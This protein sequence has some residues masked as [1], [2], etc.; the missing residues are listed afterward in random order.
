M[1]H[2]VLLRVK[3]DKPKFRQQIT[4]IS[5]RHVLIWFLLA[6]FARAN[7][8][9][10]VG[11]G[12]QLFF[13]PKI[14]PNRSLRR[15]ICSSDSVDFRLQL[16]YRK[17]AF[18]RNHSNSSSSS[19]SLSSS[20]SAIKQNNQRFLSCLIVFVRDFPRH[21][22]PVELTAIS[23][24]TAA[25]ALHSSLPH[26]ISKLAPK[27]VALICFVVASLWFNFIGCAFVFC[28]L[29]RPFRN[30]VC[31]F[32]YVCLHSGLFGCRCHQF[33]RIHLEH[34]S[35][36]LPFDSDFDLF[37]KSLV[38]VESESCLLSFIKCQLFLRNFFFLFFFCVLPDRFGRRIHLTFSFFLF[39]V[40]VYFFMLLVSI[41]IVSTLCHL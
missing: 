40:C 10:F 41:L 35:N 32:V 21:Q 6:T 8:I 24:P 34:R 25:A 23:V 31:R 28:P 18:D 13:H 19:S 3:V 11:L 17:V 29:F 12:R 15:P 26:F 33:F 38:S 22:L 4:S 14:C 37:T 36:S 30:T 2:P 39:F 9:S 1:L 16:S 20:S 7:L 27:F 5:N